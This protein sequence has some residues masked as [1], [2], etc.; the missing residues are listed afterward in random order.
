MSTLIVMS[1]VT[2]AP[3]PNIGESSRILYY[4]VPQAWVCVLAFLISV[5]FSIR[6]L[7][8][9]SMIEDSR[10][11]AAAALGFVF[12]LL[13]TATGSIFARV[14]W[15]S[16]WNWDPRQ[17]SIFILLLIYGA[18]FALRRAI[19]TQ[20]RCAALSAVYSI[21]AFV[22]VPFLV[23]VMPRIVPSLHPGDAVVSEDLSLTMGPAVR[24]IFSA[25][26]ALFTAL[27]FWIYSLAHRVQSLSSLGM[28]EDW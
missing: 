3:Q 27:F 13:A 10:A 24:I 15:G 22:T 8:N 23:F 28:E 4:H 17:I 1:F 5:V 6:Y 9:R 18:Y 2:P 11:A 7:R 21:F 12:C 14:T 20:D 26:L 25:S 16:F 19:D